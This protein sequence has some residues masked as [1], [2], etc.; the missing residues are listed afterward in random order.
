LTN[1]NIKEKYRSYLK[2][3]KRGRSKN[4]KVLS[5]FAQKLDS[6]GSEGNE[7][8]SLMSHTFHSIMTEIRPQGPG[9]D[10]EVVDLTQDEEDKDSWNDIIESLNPYAQ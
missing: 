3:L 5:T 7:L 1:G 2:L 8:I 6:E 4:Y 9:I 10:D